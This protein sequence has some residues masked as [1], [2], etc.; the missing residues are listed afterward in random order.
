MPEISIK[1]QPIGSIGSFVITNSLLSSFVAMA[2]FL[3]LSALYYQ[4]SKK[5]KKSLLYYAVTAVLKQLYVLFEGVVQDKKDVFFGILGAFFLFILFQN[6]TGLL[7]GWGSILVHKV[8]LLRGGSADLNTTLALGIISVVLMQVY[9]VY[10]LGFKYFKKFFNLSN[11]VS[12]FIGILDILSEF[13]RII[14]FSFRLFGNIF[15]GEVLLTIISFLVPV[16]VS[17][18]FLVMEFFVGF[19]QALVFTLLTAVFLQ[20]AVAEHH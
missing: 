14:S 16:L 9:G 18:P 2:I 13:S 11:P 19:I 10:F 17:F 3:V 12:F 1:A 6:W 7:P 8:P 4:E 5:T 15:A 20:M